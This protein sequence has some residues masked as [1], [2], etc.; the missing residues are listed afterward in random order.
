MINLSIVKRTSKAGKEYECLRLKIGEYET[1]VF[2]TKFELMYVKDKLRA[3]AQN[4]FLEQGGT[5]E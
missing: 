1:L 4:D 2:L 5:L 3:N